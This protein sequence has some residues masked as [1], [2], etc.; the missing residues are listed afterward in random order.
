MGKSNYSRSL[1]VPLD[2]LQDS[3]ISQSQ[4]LV[5][6]LIIQLDNDMGCYATNDYMAGFLGISKR[7]VQKHIK[8]LIDTSYL[9]EP[10]YRLQ[11][12]GDREQTLRVFRGVSKMTSHEQKGNLGVSKSSPKGIEERI[13]IFIAEVENEIKSIKVL[14]QFERD[15]MKKFI[16]YWTEKTRNKKKFLQETKPTWETKKRWSTWM[17]GKVEK[18]SKPKKNGFIDIS[19]FPTE[20]TG[21]PRA[22]CSECGTIETYK[23]VWDMKGGSRCHGAILQP[24]NPALEQLNAG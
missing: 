4:K 23:D 1:I 24:E 7:Q 13:N 5:L 16:S 3:D 20:T 14:S 8:N 9:P 15:E 6:S 12:I 22:Y 10:I 18:N 19:K 2:I 11:K 17:S 21:M